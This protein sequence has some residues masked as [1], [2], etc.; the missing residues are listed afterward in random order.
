MAAGPGCV[1]SSWPGP[2]SEHTASPLTSSRPE[3]SPRSSPPGGGWWWMMVV[4]ILV[5]DRGGGWGW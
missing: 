4:V 5:Y 3:R 1:A 2:W